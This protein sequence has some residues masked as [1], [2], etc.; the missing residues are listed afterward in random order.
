MD[1][2]FAWDAYKENLSI[3]GEA[4]SGK[5]NQALYLAKILELNG[6]N[7]LIRDV[8]RRFTRINPACVK[9]NLW[10]LRGV[11]LEIYQPINDTHQNFIDLCAFASTLYNCVFM[12]DELHNDSSAQS[13]NNELKFFCRN[14]NNRSCSYVGIFQAPAEVPKFVVRN[15]HHRFCYQLDVPT[16]IDYLVRFIGAEVKRFEADSL[17]PVERYHCLYKPPRFR[18]KEMYFPE[19]K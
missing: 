17:D 2:G 4:Q 16:D 1:F 14:C 11:G 3:M 15:S 8:H 13:S 12:I 6:F 5:T 10:D 19:F 18:A 9:T 7:I